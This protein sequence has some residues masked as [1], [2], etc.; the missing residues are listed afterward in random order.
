MRRVDAAII[1]TAWLGVLGFS[2]FAARSC[3]PPKEPEVPAVADAGRGRLGAVL[4]DGAVTGD[5]VRWLDVQS[6]APVGVLLAVV[7]HMTQAI[8]DGGIP[9]PTYVPPSGHPEWTDLS[10]FPTQG[11]TREVGIRAYCQVPG[12][13][14]VAMTAVDALEFA[15]LKNVI[16]PISVDAGV[17][18]N[19]C[20]D[21]EN[22]PALSTTR[23]PLWDGDGGACWWEGQA[24]AAV[25]QPPDDYDGGAP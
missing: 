14:V 1:A 5:V 23:P 20:T 3:W 22:L 25:P 4:P 12:R 8:L 11:T 16:C 17:F 19:L 18:V 2:A 9:G 13:Y 7:R 6:P 15:K 24:D 21:V 10:Q